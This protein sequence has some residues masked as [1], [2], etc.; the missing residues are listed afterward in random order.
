ML[1]TS[2]L[3]NLLLHTHITIVINLCLHVVALCDNTYK[4]VNSKANP[5][6]HVA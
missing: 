5:L 4:H 1:I 2:Q 3:T 6:H